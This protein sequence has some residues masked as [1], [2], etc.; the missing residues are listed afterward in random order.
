[1]NGERENAW[2]LTRRCG[3]RSGRD[4]EERGTG[5]LGDQIEHDRRG[6]ENSLRQ[7]HELPARSKTRWTGYVQ[8]RDKGT[9]RA[10]DAGRKS[11]EQNAKACREGNEW[12]DLPVRMATSG[13]KVRTHSGKEWH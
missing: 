4:V 10:V 7:T 2:R 8:D 11:T 13:M 9:D 5:S 3:V 12:K 1:M 6:S